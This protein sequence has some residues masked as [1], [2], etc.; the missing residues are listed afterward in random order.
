MSPM[1]VTRGK[2]RSRTSEER[3]DDG[4][5]IEIEML[6]SPPAKMEFDLSSSR[7]S[8]DISDVG[9]N[10]D[11][12]ATILHSRN[13]Q[14]C[15]VLVSTKTTLRELKSKIQN[16]F[17]ID[18][19]A[20]RLFYLGRELKTM[21]RSLGNIGFGNYSNT[22]IHLVSNC[23][24][25]GKL[26]FGDGGRT[27]LRK[28]RARPTLSSTEPTSNPAAHSINLMDDDV[29]L[30]DDDDDDEVEVLDDP[31]VTANATLPSRKRRRR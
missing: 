24:M 9:D 14:K 21:S 4:D 1:V 2:T 5:I 12:K 26:S 3:S 17:D 29:I 18:S 31:P 19:S 10:N 22:F 6:P 27:G 11:V 16:E 13:G 25:N 20:Q 30:L 23:T 15:E 7:E 28:N 8:N